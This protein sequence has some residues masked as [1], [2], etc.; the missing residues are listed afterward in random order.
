LVAAVRAAVAVGP[1]ADGEGEREGFAL[2]WIFQ[3]GR[4]PPHRLRAICRRSIPE[5]RSELHPLVFPFQ[6]CDVVS[7]VEAKLFDGVG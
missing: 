2:R 5:L 7:Y 1:S 3:R 6:D 4:F